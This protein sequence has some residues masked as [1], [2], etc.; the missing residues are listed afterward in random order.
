MPGDDDDDDDDCVE[1]EKRKDVKNSIEN[2]F[3]GAPMAPL[4]APPYCVLPI[5]H[6]EIVC[7]YDYVFVWM[8]VCKYAPRMLYAYSHNEELL[9]NSML[10]RFIFLPTHSG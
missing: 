9:H 2:A 1:E 10:L 7:E 3:C 8:C 6:T 4:F 5:C